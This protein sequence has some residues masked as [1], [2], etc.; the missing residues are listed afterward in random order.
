MSAGVEVGDD[1][2]PRDA[3]G[4]VTLTNVLVAGSLM[5][6]AAFAAGGAGIGFA[7]ATGMLAGRLAAAPEGRQEVDAPSRVARAI[8]RAGMEGCIGC[9]ACA[10]VCPVLEQSTIEGPWYPGPRSV[11]NL[12]RS[13]PTA[14]VSAESLSLCT[15]CGACSTVCPAGGR[16]QE[17]VVAL[18]ADIVARRPDTVPDAW[19]VV[20]RVLAE[21]GNVYGT[22]L[23]PME[24]P[25]RADAE[26]AF[27]PGCTL[28]YFERESGARTIR[29]L[30]SFGVPLSIVDGV[31]CGGPLDVL[32]LEPGADAVERNREAV[33]AT[34]ASV[35]VAACP[36]CAH[37]LSRQLG[38][39]GVC[40]EHA[41]ETVARLLPGSRVLETLRVKLGGRSVTYHD[42]CEIGRYLGRYLEA[43]TI[44]RMVGLL[45]VEMERS[46]ERSQCCGAGGGLRS[47]NPKLSREISR[48]RVSE[49]MDTGASSLLTECP[50]CLHNLRTGRRRKQSIV[51]EDL[52]AF[53]GE[54]V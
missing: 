12:G 35:V 37:M 46:M 11:G 18:R 45:V 23:A 21:A 24:G 25:R 52:T 51:V 16:N 31:C 26:I 34:G 22:S 50:S 42:P 6:G 36:R 47:V 14:D 1:M 30:E 43:R 39:D 10:S 54:A 48:R 28:Q 5:R 32:G 3:A 38:L 17:L 20:P 4:R 27:F 40:I 29:L 2:R 44:M 7:A 9:E 8:P 15:L 19:R 13:G 53:L 41:L 49:A 33:R